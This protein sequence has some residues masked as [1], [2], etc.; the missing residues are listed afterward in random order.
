MIPPHRAQTLVK[1]ALQ[2]KAPALY[3]A[4][5]QQGTLDLFLTELAQELREF[6]AAQVDRALARAAQNPH[7]DYGQAGQDLRAEQRAVEE[8]AIAT[9]LE[10]PPEIALPHEHLQ[11]WWAPFAPCA[12]V[13]G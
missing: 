10:F 2:I 5:Q 1:G 11:A 9:Y 3:R 13:R 8:Q 4:L 7:L 6:A 12:C